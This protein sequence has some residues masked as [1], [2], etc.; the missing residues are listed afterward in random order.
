VRSIVVLV[1]SAQLI[2][3]IWAIGSSATLGTS[4]VFTGN[5]LA[6]AAISLS[7]RSVVQG[8]V[9]AKSTV[10]ADSGSWLDTRYNFVSGKINI[11]T[12]AQF[13]ALAGSEITFQSKATVI[14]SG[15]IGTSTGTKINGDYELKGGQ[16]YLNTGPALTCK[17][18]FTGAYNDASVATCQN[19]LAAADLTGLILLPGVYCS[20][21]GTFSIAANGK[22]ILDA[23]NNSDSQWIFQTAT[24]VISGDNSEMRFINGGKANNVYW[25]V[26]TSHTSG[27]N[28]RFI[29][30]IL[31]Q[32]SI[33]LGSESRL[34]GR[35]FA[36]QTVT[37]SGNVS[38]S[39][40]PIAPTGQPSSAPSMQPS[41]YIYLYIYVNIYIFIYIYIYIYMSIYICIYI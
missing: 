32:T 20:D 21:P 8:R 38:T 23:Q 34:A 31:A 5:V 33:T 30:N 40:P 15:S 39:L 41:R 29:G 36:L 9:L 16:A 3:V 35:A 26:G 19:K 10:T 18:D 11:L 28:A 14:V 4:S 2:N 22:V 37:Y 27:I 12:C 13:I 6:Q 7:A 1:N 25:A 24:T 17:E